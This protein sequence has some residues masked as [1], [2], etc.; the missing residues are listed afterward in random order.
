MKKLWV[1]TLVVFATMTSELFISGLMSEMAH[2]FNVSTSQIGM[3]ITYYALAMVIGGPII[4]IA[5]IRMNPKNLLVGVTL[6]FFIGQIIG[7]LTSNYLLMVISRI[8]TGGAASVVIATSL[9]IAFHQ[10]SK[11]K[12]GEA[13]SIVLSGLMLGSIIGLPLATFVGHTYGW[14]IS[15]ISIGL[16]ILIGFIMVLIFI[17]KVHIEQDVNVLSELKLLKSKSLWFAYLTALLI[18]GATFGVSSYFEPILTKASVFTTYQLPMILGIYGIMTLIGNFVVGKLG[19]KYTF[20]ILKIGIVQMIIAFILLIIYIDNAVIV[21][22]A[23]MLFGMSGISL[24]PATVVRVINISGGSTI[25]MTFLNSMITLGVVVGT[26]IGN[27]TLSIG[28]PITSVIYS[29]VVLSVLALFTVLYV[30]K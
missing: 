22:I 29:G 2:A 3:L 30:K 11:E 26:A 12:Q 17:P 9:N 7:G 15:Y 1:L 28:L 4:T 23:I 20:A 18:I 5:F 25:V 8:V 24:N 6:I 27:L 19:D 10:V 14:K 21:I 16:L 13:S